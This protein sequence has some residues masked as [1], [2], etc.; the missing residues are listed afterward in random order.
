MIELGLPAIIGYLVGSIPVALLVGRAHG[1]DLR[2]VGDGNPGAWNAMEQLGGRAAAPV[3]AGD[4]LKG[5]AAGL[6][7][8]ALGGVWGGYAAVGG[9]MIGH[10]LPVFASFRGGKSVM[11]FAGGAFVLAPLAAAACLGACLGLSMLR[12]FK[13]GARVGVFGFP[14]AQLLVDPI[15]QVA[16]TGV[17]MS[18]IGLLYLAERLPRRLR[19]PRAAAVGR[20]RDKA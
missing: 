17:L 1:I 14:L 5:L 18:L 2:E 10:A 13:V 3:F 12:S 11:T 9:A 4:G 15:E 7:G 20:H 8:L 16:A 19:A 6:A